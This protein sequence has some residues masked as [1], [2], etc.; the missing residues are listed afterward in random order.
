MLDVAVSFL[1]DEFNAYL[2]RRTGSTTVGKMAAG[3]VMNDLGKL[4]I[5]SGSIG[6][7]L[8]N[9]EEERVVRAQL[10]ERM[11]VKGSQVTLQ[12]E[13]RLNLT[14]LFAANLTP[15]EMSLRGL[16]QVLT[17]FQSHPA[18][19][20][21]EYPGLDP[22]IG[23]LVV[24]MMSYGPEQLNQIWAYLGAKYLPSVIYRVRMV[25]LQDVEPQGIGEPITGIA[26]DLHDK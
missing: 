12:P 23:R 17:F 14:L 6:A 24:E 5:A 9:V 20:S 1:A 26:L 8:I 16:S 19:A 18:F 10:P 22:R 21:D 25:V 7:C 3:P 4:A 13:L 15:Y 11:L 2:L